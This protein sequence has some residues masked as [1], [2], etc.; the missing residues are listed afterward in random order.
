MKIETPPIVALFVQE[1]GIYS[2]LPG[3]ECWPESRDARTYSGFSPVV[4]HPP[5]AAWGRYHQKA[6][7]LGNDGGCFAS[8]LASVRRCGGVL[9]HPAT[10]QAWAHYE[11]PKPFDPADEFG[12]W[13]LVVLQRWW[14]HEA[15]KPTLLYV[16]GVSRVSVLVSAIGEGLR[17]L[18]HLSKIQR[19][20]TPR[21]F[22]EW[23]VAIARSV[24]APL[25]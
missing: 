1:A 18:E 20:A 12:G 25:W 9:E 10:S 19:A 11:L 8:A 15:L 22:A 17:P 2:R 16:V 23:L 13:S 24:E 6:G 7:G 21:A 3:V 4:A 5:C 14:G